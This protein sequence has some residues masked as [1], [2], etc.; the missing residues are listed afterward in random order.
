MNLDTFITESLKAI[1]KGV[2]E[3]QDFAHQNKASI[4]PQL[5][6]WD[7]NKTYATKDDLRAVTPID[8]DIAVTASNENESGGNAGINVLSFSL[9]GKLSDKKLTETVSRLKFTVN[10][11]LPNESQKNE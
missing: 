7:M 9:G 11:A 3:T 10:V 5:A 2:K 8:F 4:N 1:I 6:G